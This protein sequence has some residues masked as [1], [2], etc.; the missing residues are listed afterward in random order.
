MQ[1]PAW[2]TAEVAARAAEALRAVSKGWLTTMCKVRPL[3]LSTWPAPFASS[4]PWFLEGVP[5]ASNADGSLSLA[6]GGRRMDGSAAPHCRL[7]HAP[8][9]R[10]AD[11]LLTVSLCGRLRVRAC[12]AQAFVAEAPEAR[13]NLALAI[14]AY[15]A[16]SDAGVVAPLFRTAI[17]RLTKV[18]APS[19][20]CFSRCACW[21]VWTLRRSPQPRL[22]IPRTRPWQARVCVCVG[23]G[24]LHQF[25][26]LG[27]AEAQLPGISDARVCAS[28]C[29]QIMADAAAEVPPPD[30]VT[31]GGGTPSERRAT[32]TEVALCLASGLPDEGLETL[33]KVSAAACLRNGS[34]PH[35]SLPW[36]FVC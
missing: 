14:S 11:C 5:F 30:Q 34:P 32:F 23:G 25:G 35:A 24:D 33:L 4:L 15:S 2:Y 13:G 26:H 1:P 22:G 28:P 3:C 9:V 36:L 8:V 17:T 27:K 16:I 21:H 20:F 31:D 29:P 19:R 12:A 6:R 18:R 7:P 10:P